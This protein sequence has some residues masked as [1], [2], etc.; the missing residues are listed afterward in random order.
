MATILSQLIKLRRLIKLPYEIRYVDR[1]IEK[2]EFE[3]MVIY[4]HIKI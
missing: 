4:I 1:V 2:E 3:E